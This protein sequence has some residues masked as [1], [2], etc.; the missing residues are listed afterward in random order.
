[1]SESILLVTISSGPTLW[2]V[3]Q[4]HRPLFT[5]S[6]FHHS[7]LP[8]RILSGPPWNLFWP[9]KIRFSRSVHNKPVIQMTFGV[10]LRAYVDPWRRRRPPTSHLRLGPHC[11]GRVLRAVHHKGCSGQELFLVY[12]IWRFSSFNLLL[13]SCL[14]KT[15]DGRFRIYG[16][17]LFGTKPNDLVPFHDVYSIKVLIHLAFQGLLKYWRSQM[18]LEWN[19]DQRVQAFSH[20]SW[21]GRSTIILY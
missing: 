6:V 14:S 9:L 19:I 4:F 18:R 15:G 8:S 20:S 2:T 17:H 1:M 12:Y 21:Q 13:H 10:I 16:Q 5:S 3:W 11:Y 7:P